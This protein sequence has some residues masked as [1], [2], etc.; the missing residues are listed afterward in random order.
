MTKKDKSK[1]KTPKKTTKK[2][3]QAKIW[4]KASMQFAK[5]TIGSSKG[6]RVYENTYRT[7]PLN[8]ARKGTSGSKNRS[9][10]YRSVTKGMVDSSLFIIFVLLFISLKEYNLIS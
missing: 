8:N 6:T 1:I 3:R 4:K 9:K 10:L 7:P 2:M 5:A